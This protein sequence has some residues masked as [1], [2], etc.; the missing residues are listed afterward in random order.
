MMMNCLNG[1]FADVYADSLGEALVRAPNGGGI[2]V[3]ASSGLSDSAIQLEM[4]REAFRRLRESSATLG[5]AVRLAKGGVTDADVRRTWVLLGDPTLASPLAPG[6]P[7]EAPVALG[8]SGIGVSEISETGVTIS[9]KTSRA[10]RGQ[11]EY[12][13]T[14]DYG[15]STRLDGRLETAHTRMLTGLS[16]GT[17][18]HFRVTAVDSGGKVVHSEDG[19]FTTAGMPATGPEAAGGLTAGNPRI[20]AGETG[21]AQRGG[22]QAGA[23]R[24]YWV[25]PLDGADAGTA[26]LLENRGGSATE[27]TFA[28]YD[29][30]RRLASG[31][32]MVNP[33]HRELSPGERVQVTARELFGAVSGRFVIVQADESVSVSIR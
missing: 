2:A 14:E 11:V 33:A 31:S 32:G 25:V 17:G 19:T 23:Q 22:I 8:I 4:G 29:G 30:D 21:D 28:L 1:Y 16:S 10:A 15:R 13:T 5:E 24:K 12:G 26:I 3:W 18:Y 20:G 9:W 6:A 7:A 27:V